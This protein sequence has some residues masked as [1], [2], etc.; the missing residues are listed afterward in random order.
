MKKY[1]T[2]LLGMIF[3]FSSAFAQ[4][5]KVSKGDSVTVNVRFEQLD[6]NKGDKTQKDAINSFLITTGDALTTSINKLT[7][8]AEENLKLQQT[9]KLDMVSKE[10][11]I[12]KKSITNMYKLNI[13][14]L[15]LSASLF[16]ILVSYSLVSF[17]K[18]GINVE[19]TIVATIFLI[20]YGALFS[21]LLYVILTLLFNK[22][23]FIIKD[24][25]S[26][27]I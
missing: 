13:T 24:V 20:I 3:M 26:S 10:M 18:K 5:N 23:Y 16:F 2:L 6:V 19:H 21:G 14:F 4:Q 8:V 1:I 7:T 27:L 15:L 17:L 22:Q 25:L 12:S 11:S 9:S